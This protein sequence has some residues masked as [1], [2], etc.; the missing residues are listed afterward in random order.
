M[1]TPISANAV[2]A[3]EPAGRAASGSGFQPPNSRFRKPLLR[4]GSRSIA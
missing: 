3:R 4:V 2:P 1:V